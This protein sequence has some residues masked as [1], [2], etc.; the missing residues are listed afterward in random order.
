MK[1]TMTI[2]Q[3][4]DFLSIHPHGGSQREAFEELCCQIARVRSA[5]AVSFERYR[6]AGGDGGVECL[7]RG[8]DGSVI[9]WQAKY[10]FNIDGLI[11]QF[12]ESLRA[13]LKVH[14]DL[15]RYV[16]CFPFDPTGKT[17]R[18]GKSQSEKF[19][20][21]A[22]EATKGAAENGHNQLQASPPGFLQVV[23]N[24]CRYSAV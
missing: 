15:T 24:L 23:W 19:A 14:S 20:D 4:I 13:A 18:K 2:A 12:A 9:G 16:V 10:V 6:G 11:K 5:A 17:A 21:W 22:A 1:P 7:A 3:R 8:E